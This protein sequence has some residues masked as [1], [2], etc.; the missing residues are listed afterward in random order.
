[1]ILKDSRESLS[2][3]TSVFDFLKPSSGTPALPSALLENGD[4]DGDDDDEQITP[5]LHL[6]TVLIGDSVST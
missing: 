3:H 2:L 5:P 4:G 1:V 6:N